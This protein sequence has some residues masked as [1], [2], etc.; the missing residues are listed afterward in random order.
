MPWGKKKSYQL[1]NKKK[2]QEFNIEW[3]IYE[4]WFEK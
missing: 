3:Y 2:R 1:Q 4:N